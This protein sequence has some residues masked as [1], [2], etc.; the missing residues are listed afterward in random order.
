MAQH[1]KF[2]N[3]LNKHSGN[4][5]FKEGSFVNGDEETKLPPSGEDEEEMPTGEEEVPQEPTGE[6]EAQPETSEEEAQP[7]TSEMF[8]D[9][10][11]DILNVALQIYRANPDNSIESKNEFSNMFERD[12]FESLLGRLITIADELSE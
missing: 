12:R 7:E 5:L 3:I 9:R 6:E 4:N 10:E 1:S 2:I 11:Q 8:S